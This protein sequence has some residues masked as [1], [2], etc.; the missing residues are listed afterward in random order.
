[1]SAAPSVERSRGGRKP[2]RP[3]GERFGITLIELLVV[4]ALIGV[5]SGV[6]AFAVAGSPGST[7]PTSVLDSLHRRAVLT[8]IPVAVEVFDSAAGYPVRI[9]FLP[10]GRLLGESV[11]PV[12]GRLP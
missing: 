6:V 8:G 9:R 1:M 2:A 4:L 11:D 7:K 12:K 10:D 3:T 5:V